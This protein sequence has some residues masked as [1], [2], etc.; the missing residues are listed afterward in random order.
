MINFLPQQGRSHRQVARRAGGEVQLPFWQ[1][2]SLRF[3]VASRCMQR[4]GVP[5]FA[6]NATTGAVPT[7]PNPA[8][9]P[10]F[11]RAVRRGS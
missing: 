5:R 2:A 6:C 10:R 11:G 9:P 3:I 7:V 8:A 1:A 4:R